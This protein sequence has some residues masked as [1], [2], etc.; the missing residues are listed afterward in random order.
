MLVGAGAAER[1]LAKLDDAARY[2]VDVQ[3]ATMPWGQPM[4]VAL[5]IPL[6]G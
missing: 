2:R 6:G 4:D 5:A 1:I 3:Q